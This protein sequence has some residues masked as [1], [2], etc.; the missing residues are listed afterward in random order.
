VEIYEREK[1][2]K[3]RACAC[4]CAE[5]KSCAVCGAE[6]TGRIRRGTRKRQDIISYNILYIHKLFVLRKGQESHIIY[7]YIIPPSTERRTIRVRTAHET[8]NP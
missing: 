2:N 8:C 7:I 6:M 1:Y 5:Y 3:P 4:E